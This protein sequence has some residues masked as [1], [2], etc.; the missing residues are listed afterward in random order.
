MKRSAL[1]MVAI[2][3][4]G[5]AVQAD[6][7]APST[8]SYDDSGAIDESLTGTP[9]DPE[10]GRLVMATKSQGN[11]I[12]CHAVTDLSDFPF[13]GEVGPSLDGVGSR[14]DE[15]QLRGI[16][17]D[18]KHTF[19]GT[20]MP[21]FYK[22]EGFIRPGRAFTGN[23]IP[24]DEIEPLLTAQQIEDVVAYLMTLQDEG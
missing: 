12:A 23:A 3:L 15:A 21:S 10:N 18:A 19:P 4:G 11:C 2:L 16:V 7:V 6:V 20:I 24:E 9:G 5:S 13:H 8:V 1:A 22:V 17:A 14:W